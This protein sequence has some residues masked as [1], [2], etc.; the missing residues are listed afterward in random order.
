MSLDWCVALPPDA[1][2]LSAV[3]D[4]GIP[5]HTLLLF[6]CIIKNQLL[7]NK[8]FQRRGKMFDVLKVAKNDVL[9]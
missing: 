5:D 3:C 2:G 1:M 7:N 6:F 9:E 8:V 4:C